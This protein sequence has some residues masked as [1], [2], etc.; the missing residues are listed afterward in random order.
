MCG[1]AGVVRQDGAAVD[2]DL[3]RRM[4]GALAHRGP[5]GDGFYFEGP[6]GLGHRRLAIIDLSG[7]VQ[8]MAVDGGAFRIT[9][10]GELY[11]YRELRRELVGRGCDFETKSDTEVVLQA[12]RAWGP[13]CLRRFRGMFA[14]AIWDARARLLFAARD[15]LGIKPLV[16]AWDGTCLRFASEIKALLQDPALPRR[17]D[18][19]ALS[20]YLTY[21]YVPTPRTIFSDVKKLPPASYLLFRPDGGEPEINRYWD[22]D[23]TTRATGSEKEWIERLGATL[24]EAVK[25]QMVSDVPIGAFL[26]GGVDSST[27]VAC[28]AKSSERKVK[29]FSIGF[30]ES[31]F[32]ELAYARQVAAR[33]DTEHFEMVL[34]PDVMSVVPRLAWQ[35]DEPFAD[36][37]AVPTYCVSRITR[38]HVTVALSGDGGDENFAGYRRYTEAAAL[39]ERLDRPPLSLLRPLL[40]RLGAMR[41]PGARGKAYLQRRGLPPID[42]YHD[43]V[44]YAGEASLKALLEPD[45]RG[46]R[47]GAE[48][49]R[50]LAAQSG[51]DDYVSALQYIDVHSYLP[52]DILTKVDRASMLT[53]LETRVP[54][55]DHVLMEEVAAMPSHVKLRDGVGKY[56]LKE[57]MRPHLPP[58]VLSRRKMGFGVPLASWL[59][60][61]LR[62]FTQDVL[63]DGR[64]RQRGIM[65]E[66]G[67]RDLLSRHLSGGRDYSPQIWSLICFEL[68]ARTWWDR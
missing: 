32:D 43:T 44:T 14:F 60:N 50:R 8:P 33:H 3:V 30:D 63:L 56:I 65:R 17:L 48:A 35:F 54:L 59:R 4:T 26:S 28:M 61:D 52:D 11:N 38:E 41:R 6:V 62:D 42:R 10:N 64:A 20:D 25:L 12:Y 1:I 2:S 36:A 22:L 39:H 68:W 37:S 9:Y 13:D 58:E 40:R 16:Y 29:T 49:F 45:A 21:H 15:H 7:G 23:L 5:D 46:S 55:L 66:G 53:S 57:V 51:T 27:V 67:V 31:D 47:G 24:M 34:K 19:D 18:R